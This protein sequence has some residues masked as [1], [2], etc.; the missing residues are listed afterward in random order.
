MVITYLAKDFELKITY[1]MFAIADL[2]FW[3]FKV[4]KC[5]LFSTCLIY[6]QSREIRE[7]QTMAEC[8]FY[9]IITDSV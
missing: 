7:K 6:D 5:Y 8:M 1:F 3:H 2:L 4:Q 9:Y